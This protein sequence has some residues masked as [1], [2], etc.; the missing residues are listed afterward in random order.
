MNESRVF[1]LGQGGQFIDS[2]EIG[3]MD[4]LEEDMDT[5]V[6]NKVTVI[7]INIVG[8]WISNGRW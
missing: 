8:H 3:G 4:E 2:E 5:I 6:H 7:V 1:Y